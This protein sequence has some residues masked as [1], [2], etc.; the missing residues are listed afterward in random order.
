MQIKKRL[1]INVALSL[2]TAVVIGIMLSLSL[3]RLNKANKLAE[4]TGGIV[5]STLEK[6]TLRNDYMITHSS[7]AKAQW[8][9]KDEQIDKL[10]KLALDSFREAEDRKYIAWLMEDHASL[11]R[12]FSAIVANRE[13]SGFDQ[14]SNDSSQEV[15][16]RL[17]NQM[18]MRVYEADI[19]SRKLLVSS[20][21][22]RASAL[23]QAGWGV[24]SALLLIIGA[25]I[26]NS[27]TMYRV[28]VDRI[29]L[30]RYGA[31]VIG[32][33]NLDHR[34]DIK[35]DDELA[36]LS[37]AFNAM[38][39][40]LGITYNELASEI[41]ERK[42]TEE[43]LRESE[44][45][46]ASF[47]LHL[48]AATWIKDRQ[49]RYV[50]ANAE[51]ERVFSTPWPALQGKTDEEVFP[52]ETA[53]MFRENDER[54]MAE[55]GHLRTMEILRQA[56]QIEHHSIVSK[57]AVPGPDGQPA[58]VAGVALDITE[59][60]RAEEALKAAQRESER[61]GAE[62]TALMNAVPA[63]V[64]ISHDVECSLIYGNRVTQELLGLPAITNFAKSAPSAGQP[65]N[66]LA[67]KDGREIPAEQLPV[68]T[69]ARGRELIDYEFDLVL[70][71]GRVRTLLGNAAPLLDESG[72]P[73]G[74][75]GAFVDIT[76][77]KRAENE[78]SRNRI[79][80]EEAE[81]LAR[82][83]AW[84]L[85][86]ANKRFHMSPE[87]QRIHGSDD[88]DPSMETLMLIAHPDDSE[89]ITRAFQTS[90]ETGVPYKIAH[91]IVRLSD[92]EVRIIEAYGSVIRDASGKPVRMYGA[93]QD[94]TERR[95]IED[96]LIDKQNELEELNSSLEERI[97]QAV[98]DLR[99]KDQLLIIQG[100]QAIMGEMISN[101]AHQW[102]Q[103]LNMLGLLAQELPVIYKHGEFSVEYLDANVKKS[104]EL[105]QYMS[106]TIDDFRYFF[107]PDT[108]KVQF[109]AVEVIEKAV[110][111]LEGSSAA[112]GIKTELQATGDPCVN[113]YPNEF[114][115]VILNII[116]NARDAL[117]ARKAAN[118][119]LL[120]K[121]Y[122]ENSR[123]VVTISDNAG[124]I[125]EEIIESIFDPYFT[126]KGPDKGTGLGLHM[127]KTIIEKNMNGTLKVRNLVDGAEFR[128]E[129]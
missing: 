68:Q 92:G 1:Q 36:E 11:S 60:K 29:S 117:L 77:R 4:I 112:H 124:G 41:Q 58:Y 18:N 20:R 7:R 99:V 79:L 71:D 40:R 33:G 63:A 53:R 44:Q 25:V 95:R 38:A 100:R 8:Y 34:I 52:P 22:A 23:R 56:D 115:Q 45:R 42:R 98:N 61:Y 70:A 15:E 49:G 35:G 107:K 108:E 87:W 48:P 89:A 65:S 120:I 96:A 72:R 57:F 47:M 118:P 66:F 105:I 86:L 31:S 19:H 128:I 122:T 73:R 43:T 125:P 30:L 102:R 39:A 12:I 82:V 69:A 78:S 121:A 93:A 21:E 75:I 76:D 50:Y 17:L 16:E 111:L 10:L 24:V 27:W 109:K 104:L 9:S 84:E 119:T 13:K 81:K 54:V 126:T 14:G 59:R 51:A 113:G 103:P 62:M 116:S 94:I 74:A 64:F 90:I 37:A 129:I 28:I 127:A 46:F 101:I 88:P 6:V 83:G 2:L 106:K 97:L 3:Y 26:I 91:R 85:D 5:L 123:T 114:A 110:S 32:H 55:G 67:M 80:L